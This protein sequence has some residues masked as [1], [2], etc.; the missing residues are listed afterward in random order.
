MPLGINL[1]ISPEFHLD[2]L[3]G[4]PSATFLIIFKCHQKYPQICLPLMLLRVVNSVSNFTDVC[5]YECVYRKTHIAFHSKLYLFYSWILSKAISLHV[6][7]IRFK[8]PKV[9]LT[10]N[11]DQLFLSNM[12]RISST[13]PELWPF[14]CSGPLLKKE[15]KYVVADEQCMWH[16]KPRLSVLILWMV[17]K[18]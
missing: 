10:G 5:V 6:N 9:H 8:W 11:L 18:K 3:P 13:I 12:V 2:M 4:I 7:L 16:I 14:L 1:G 15:V 17:S